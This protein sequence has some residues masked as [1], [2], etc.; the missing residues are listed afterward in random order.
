MAPSKP[1]CLP[2]MGGW[3][4]RGRPRSD[5]HAG[6]GQPAPAQ[7][8]QPGG[9]GEQQANGR[10]G[11]GPSVPAQPALQP[12]SVAPGYYAVLPGPALPTGYPPAYV[13]SLPHPAGGGAEEAQL[14]WAMQQSRDAYVAGQAARE[15][16][17]QQSI[18]KE[19]AAA[20]KSR[21]ESVSSRWWAHGA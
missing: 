21:A 14:A 6:D 9:S 11:A 5:H 20:T 18:A 17:R 19:R 3:F 13:I 10:R 8:G 12:P 16:Q 1:G 15:R 7:Q 4:G 2:V